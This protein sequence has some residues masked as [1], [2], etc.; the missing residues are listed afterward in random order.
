MLYRFANYVE[1]PASAFAGPDAPFTIGILGADALADELAEFA[2]GRTILDRRL[3]VR[4]LRNLETIRDV[5]VLF[6]GGNDP[7]S[8]AATAR[9]RYPGL[10]IVTEAEGALQR[11]S[12]INFILVSGQVRFEISIDSA[13]R[14][15]LKLSSRLLSVAYAVQPEGL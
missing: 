8:I 9:M 4:R 10:L 5:Q 15:N 14:S 2:A 7:P 3:Q 13:R 6:I 11:G 1:W 12:V